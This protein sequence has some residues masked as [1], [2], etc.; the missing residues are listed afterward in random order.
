MAECAALVIKK[1]G[2][3][4]LFGRGLSTRIITNGLQG[5]MF[6]VMWRMGISFLASCLNPKV[7]HVVLLTLTLNPNPKPSSIACRAS[8]LN[9][10]P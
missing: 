7:L 10:K 5:I 9:S 3:I 6:N 2:V 8:Y 4:G 1:D